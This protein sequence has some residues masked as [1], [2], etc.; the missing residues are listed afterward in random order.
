MLTNGVQKQ[1]I[2]PFFGFLIVSLFK[3][4]GADWVL[5][6]PAMG[7]VERRTRLRLVSSKAKLTRPEVA[8]EMVVVEIRKP[9]PSKMIPVKTN[10]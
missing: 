5:L 7:G 4:I 2:L 3:E 9:E 6:C 8:M 10:F 1:H